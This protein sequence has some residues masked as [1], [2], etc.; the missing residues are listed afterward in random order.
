PYTTVAGLILDRLGRLPDGP[1][2]RV[3]LADWVL[4]V[5]TVHRHAITQVRAIPRGLEDVTTHPSEE[6][7]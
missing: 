7:P 4:E 1:G 5:D 3:H 6:H 2:D